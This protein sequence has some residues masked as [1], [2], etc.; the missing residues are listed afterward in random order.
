MAEFASQVG[1]VAMGE[2]PEA[3]TVSSV[4][5]LKASTGTEKVADVRSVLQAEMMDKASVFRT[6]ETLAA[7]AATLENLRGRF[8]GVAI[9]DK[10]SRFNYDVLEALELGFLL[11]LAETVVAGARARTESRGAHFRD[12]F[13]K[14]NDAEWM[15]HTLVRREADGKLS[16]DYKPVVAGK[17]EPMERKY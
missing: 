17:Y 13:P 15:R 5:R 12:D 11:D 10:G 16:L 6:E 1:H 14:R 3:D 8:A 4:E 7:V 9:D 2:A